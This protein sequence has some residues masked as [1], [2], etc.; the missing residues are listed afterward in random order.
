MIKVE[1]AF[2][3]FLIA[4]CTEKYLVRIYLHRMMVYKQVNQFVYKIATGPTFLWE[5]NMWAI[6]CTG[7]LAE[8]SNSYKTAM[9]I[10]CLKNRNKN[11]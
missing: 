11:L 2:L 5:Y 7:N 3:L 10:F 9:H 6:I 1:P 4:I 8:R